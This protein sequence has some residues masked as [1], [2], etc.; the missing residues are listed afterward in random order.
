MEFLRIKF[1]KIGPDVFSFF[2]FMKSNYSLQRQQTRISTTW[3]LLRYNMRA[4]QKCDKLFFVCYYFKR[5]IVCFDYMGL[6]YLK[7]TQNLKHQRK[8]KKL[9]IYETELKITYIVGE[10]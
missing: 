6:I 5:K 3:G 2:V 10:K 9:H 7:C 4:Y 8:M 1:L